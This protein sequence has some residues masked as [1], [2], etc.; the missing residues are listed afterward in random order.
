MIFL[1][2]GFLLHRRD[3]GP[4]EACDARVAGIGE[5]GRSAIM[6]RDKLRESN[7]VFFQ[8]GGRRRS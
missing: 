6:I 3:N 1:V 2:L 8:G 5:G 4:G 7:N